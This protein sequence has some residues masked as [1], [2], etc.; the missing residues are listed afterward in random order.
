VELLLA[1]GVPI[2]W[3][4]GGPIDVVPLLAV[5]AA[6]LVT[7]FVIGARLT[8]VTFILAATYGSAWAWAIA[9]WGIEL[10][11]FAAVLTTAVL[12]RTVDRARAA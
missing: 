3:P 12:T 6:V 10:P 9:V 1:V 2:R 4:R 5:V 8:P 7:R 11:T